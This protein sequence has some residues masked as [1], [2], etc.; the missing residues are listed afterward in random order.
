MRIPALI[1]LGVGVSLA[2]RPIAERLVAF[3]YDRK[4]KP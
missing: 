2:F 4:D 1:L 3:I